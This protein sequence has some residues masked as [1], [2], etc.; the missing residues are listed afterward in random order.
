MSKRHRVLESVQETNP[1][2]Q[3]QRREG[4][5]RLAGKPGQPEKKQRFDESELSP[6][7][8]DNNF[9]YSNRSH[10]GTS[11]S[12]VEQKTRFTIGSFTSNDNKHRR[13]NTKKSNTVIAAPAVKKETILD[14]QVVP[15]LDPNNPELARRIQQRRR[16]ISFGKNTIGY[17]EYIKQVPKRKRKSFCPKH[18]RYGSVAR[19]LCA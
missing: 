12:I 2:G 7:T 14:G 1:A 6:S 19:Q 11:E 17:D 3:F 5:F 15:T 18:P 16:M 8:N 13:T 4:H 10:D 9:Q